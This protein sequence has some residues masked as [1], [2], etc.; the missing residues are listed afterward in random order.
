MKRE[1]IAEADRSQLRPEKETKFKSTKSDAAAHDGARVWE[2][3]GVWARGASP[4]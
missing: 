1:H 3:E 4:N 2:T